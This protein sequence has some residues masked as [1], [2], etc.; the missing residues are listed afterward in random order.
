MLPSLLR[1]STTYRDGTRVSQGTVAR[2]AEVYE[3]DKPYDAQLLY[4][5]WIEV[6]TTVLIIKDEVKRQEGSMDTQALSEAH[7]RVV[8]L[9]K[10]ADKH[11]SKIYNSVHGMDWMLEILSCRRTT[12]ETNAHARMLERLQDERSNEGS[13]IRRWMWTWPEVQEIAGSHRPD[14]VEEL[15]RRLLESGVEWCTF[16]KESAL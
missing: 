10:K 1:H 12:G 6:L 16:W 11:V 9:L 13:I 5:D 8:S 2:L 14:H 7:E 15:V 3:P 4:R